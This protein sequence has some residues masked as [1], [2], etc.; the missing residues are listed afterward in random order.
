MY[1]LMFSNQFS[2]TEPCVVALRRIKKG[3]EYSNNFLFSKQV[4]HLYPD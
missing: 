3:G 4:I 1:V 2:I